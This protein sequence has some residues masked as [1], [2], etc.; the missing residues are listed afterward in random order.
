MGRAEDLR[1]LLR[2]RVA[3]LDGATGTYLMVAGMPAGACLELWAA[4]HQDVLRRMHREYAE[5]GADVCLT[6]TFGGTAAKLPEGEDVARVNGV[7]AQAAMHEVGDRMIVAGSV[8]PTGEVMYPSGRLR[9]EE[10][11]GL[12]KAQMKALAGEGVEV[13]FL[14][15]FSDPRELKAA[16]LAAR[17]VCPNGFV[18][19][20]MSFG[21]GDRTLA[22][23]P[24]AALV[25]LADQLPVDAVGANCSVGPERMLPVAQ[26]MARFSSKPVVV[27]PNAGLPDRDG[28]YSMTPEEFAGWAEDMAWAGVSLIGGC[29]G[30]GPEHVSRYVELVGRRP[31]QEVEK[32]G[33]RAVTSLDTVVPMGR[34]L[35]SIGEKLNPTGRKPLRKAIRSEDVD[36]IVSFARSQES[37]DLL[38]VNLGLEKMVPEGLV[39]ELIPKL[40]SG[41]PLSVDLSSPE[42]LRQA[43]RRLGGVGV[44]NSLTA[45]EKDIASKVEILL[46]HGGYAVLLPIDEKGLGETPEERL[47]KIERGLEI[48]REKGFPEDRVVADPIVQSMAAGNDPEV[49]LATLRLLRKRGLL[50]VAGVSNVSHGLPGRHRLNASF[51]SMLAAEGLDLAIVDVTERSV[52]DALVGS[53]VLLGRL[54]PAEYAATA[55]PE[56]DEEEVKPSAEEELRRAILSGDRHA[57][58]EISGKLLR[59]KGMVP[60]RLIEACLAPAMQR[61]GDLYARRKLFL[62]HLVASAEAAEALMEKIRPLLGESEAV[63]GTVVLASVKGDIHDIGKNLVALFL[64]NAGFRVVD[65]GRD[66]PSEEIVETASAENADL[67]ALSALMSTTAPRM[68]EV[69][70][71][72]RSRGLG[73]RV[74]VGGAVV[75]PDYAQ[76]IGADGYA[77]DAWKA[78]ELA[79]ELV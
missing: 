10:A 14:E 53:Q 37:A 50:T 78:A 64:R 16:A 9:W 30:T 39:S 1:S 19:A 17:D 47:S 74:M 25:V 45:M 70:G 40:A 69:I 4:D 55:L 66:V 21:E 5:A 54:D 2:Q 67:V 22:G 71:L 65:L 13:F 57:V 49:T 8:G 3:F 29:C 73:A 68:E 48:L 44:L 43:F 61:V 42:L 52:G 12:F 60:S 15:T 23:T 79:L 18:S 63:K 24:P 62:P 77:P 27:E 35:L 33:I 76:S 56:E 75:G 20:Q 36:W 51:L 26:E 6:C 7:L 28:G 38:D 58:G 46:R 31:A 59:E 41:P 72:L 34:G 32:E 11:Y